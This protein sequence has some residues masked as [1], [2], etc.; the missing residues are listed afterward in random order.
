MCHF[1]YFFQFSLS[2]SHI[3]H[4]YLIHDR[5]CVIHRWNVR[6]VL[7]RTI[8][9]VQDAIP[10]IERID[11][12]IIK[13]DNDNDNPLCNTQT[14]CTEYYR[15]ALAEPGMARSDIRSLRAWA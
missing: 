3:H 7:Y 9:L 13:N 2:R 14:P 4:A 10:R 6:I 11:A 8:L 15:Y 12:R 1:V 5:R